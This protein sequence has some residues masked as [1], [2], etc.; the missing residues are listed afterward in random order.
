MKS[1]Y[2][3]TGYSNNPLIVTINGRSLQF[4]YLSNAFLSGYSN[5]VYSNNPL[6]VT[7]FLRT[8]GCLFIIFTPYIVTFLCFQKMTEYWLIVDSKLS[9]F[10]THKIKLCST[11]YTYAVQK[12]ALASVGYI[13][14]SCGDKNVTIYGV[15]SRKML[16]YA[17]FVHSKQKLLYTEPGYSKLRIK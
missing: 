4:P 2:S 5:I 16:L 6:T 17:D 9:Y 7:Y 10:S 14:L 12:N 13:L 3:N 1:V 8:N 11:R 15:S